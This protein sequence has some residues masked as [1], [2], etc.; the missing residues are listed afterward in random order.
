M[1][2]MPVGCYKKM[3]AI[4]EGVIMRLQSISIPSDRMRDITLFSG[5]G[6]SKSTKRYSLK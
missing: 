4:K 2:A 5:I 3:S 1:G 6:L